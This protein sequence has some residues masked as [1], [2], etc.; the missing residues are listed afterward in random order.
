MHLENPASL[1]FGLGSSAF[2]DAGLKTG[3]PN[4]AGSP[5][6]DDVALRLARPLAKPPHRKRADIQRP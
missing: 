1:G 4:P 3:G 6:S 5:R 2:G